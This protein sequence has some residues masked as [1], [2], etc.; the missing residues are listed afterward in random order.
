LIAALRWLGGR[1]VVLP[2]TALLLCSRTVRQSPA[3]F[4]RELMRPQGTYTY[5]LRDSGLRVIVRHQGIDAATLSEVF[6]QRFYEPPEAVSGALGEPAMIVDLGANV[7]LFGAFAAHRWPTATILAFEPDPDNAAVH[8]RTIAAND[9]LARRWT[10]SEAAAGARDGLVAFAAGLDVDSHVVDEP[11][12]AQG[13][14]S[15]EVEMRDVLPLLAD[16]DLV[17]MDIEG[18]E[19]DVLLDPRFA[20]RPPRAI[21]LE[22]HPRNSPRADTRAAVVE[23]LTIAG[24]EV[25]PIWH[26]EDGHGMIWGRRP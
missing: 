26:R 19:W 22:Y 14:R 4:V 6:Y 18:G 5:K 1:P 20:K 8:R 21:V 11:G 17:K 3:F 2:A 15:I 13:S 24:L 23:A 7:G 16:A 9:G 10:L 25:A 12:S